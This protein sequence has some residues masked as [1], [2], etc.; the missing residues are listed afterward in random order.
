MWQS[1]DVGRLLKKQQDRGG[2]VACICA[3]LLLISSF[4]NLS[5]AVL[6][7]AQCPPPLATSSQWHAVWEKYQ[8]YDIRSYSFTVLPTSFSTWFWWYVPQKL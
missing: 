6:H 2:F 4:I 8:E 7:T 5:T 3:G 1:P